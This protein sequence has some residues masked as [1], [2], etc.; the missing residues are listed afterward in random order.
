[1]TVLDDK[2][3]YKDSSRPGFPRAYKT[4][5]QYPDSSNQCDLCMN[6]ISEKR[7][8]Q[9][10]RIEGRL[11]SSPRDHIPQVS[12][13]WMKAQD[14]EEKEPCLAQ[15]CAVRSPRTP[16]SVQTSCYGTWEFKRI[17]QW[18]E[19]TQIGVDMK[20]NFTPFTFWMHCYPYQQQLEL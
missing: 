8:E 13:L 2:C 15:S 1:M 16:F 11:L 7:V 17:Q 18:Y 20:S 4:G 14:A 5:L 19:N 3:L 10:E 12:S 9:R 6:T